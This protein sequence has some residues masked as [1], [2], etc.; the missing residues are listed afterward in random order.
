MQGDSKFKEILG[1]TMCLRSAWATRDPTSKPNK[2]PKKQIHGLLS[3]FSNI[4]SI[5][6]S[7]NAQ[8]TFKPFASEFCLKGEV[9]VSRDLRVFLHDVYY[10]SRYRASNI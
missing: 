4:D 8:M 3:D 9:T 10:R 7:A 1:Y 5:M 2:C 6:L